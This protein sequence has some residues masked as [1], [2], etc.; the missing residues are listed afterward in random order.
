M[1]TLLHI[2]TNI[3]PTFQCMDFPSCVLLSHPRGCKVLIVF[4]N[5]ISQFSCIFQ[6]TNGVKNLL[7]FL[8]YTYMSS[9]E[10]YIV[11]N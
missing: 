4:S 1:V 2:P 7:V 3:A 8:L 5:L 10:E 9:F 11:G 6:M